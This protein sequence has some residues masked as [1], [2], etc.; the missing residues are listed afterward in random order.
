MEN[1]RVLIS[2]RESVSPRSVHERSLVCRDMHVSWK[3]GH[4]FVTLSEGPGRIAEQRPAKGQVQ[5]VVSPFMP[6][7]HY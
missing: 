7:L 2:P 3:A 5:K 4:S 1:G 6:P